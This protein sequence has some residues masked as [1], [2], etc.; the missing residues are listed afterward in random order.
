MD[1]KY[2]IVQRLGKG[3]TG[4]AYLARDKKLSMKWTIKKINVKD[5]K[6]IAESVRREAMAL[7]RL[8]SDSIARLS[9]IYREGNNICL[10]ME[11][12]EG[13]SLKELIVEKPEFVHKNA[14][15]WAEE[16]TA[17]VSL[18][19]T[20]NPPL[21]YRDMKPGNII[22]KENGKLCL[23]DFGAARIRNDAVSDY[24][25]VGTVGYAAPEQFLGYSDE[26]S[27][28]Y[29]LGKT[30]EKLAGGK[31]KGILGRI[32][33]KA[34]NKDPDKRY[35][36]A[37]EMYRALKRMNIFRRSIP[38]ILGLIILSSA[39]FLKISSLTDNDHYEKEI[40]DAKE[41]Y[42][43]L[44]VESG[45]AA[46]ALKSIDEYLDGAPPEDNYELCYESGI[47]ALFELSDYEK[48]ALY[49]KKAEKG[50][51]KEATYLKNISKELAVISDDKSKLKK[52]LTEF[53][54]YNRSK[55]LSEKKIRNLLYIARTEYII[56]P[57]LDDKEKKLMIE[58]AY[59]DC[60]EAGKLMEEVGEKGGFE[61]D[62]HEL[63]YLIASEMGLR[64]EALKEGLEWLET[65][66]ARDKENALRRVDE[67][68]ELCESDGERNEIVDFYEKI[69][70]F[71]PYDCGNIYLKHLEI[72]LREKA[73]K[74][75]LLKLL[76]EASLCEGIE[77]LK[78]YKEMEK[79]IKEMIYDG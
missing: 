59:E 66:G 24:E 43:K 62:C 63:A 29:A 53:R 15:K 79:K 51:I 74:G 57:V 70:K 58:A 67:M 26:R 11:Y 60:G 46:E 38:L 18:L 54:E 78:G 49:F 41:E 64:K 6:D 61:G 65:L 2:E 69:E 77:N 25:S 14:A 4:T 34:C 72:L 28:V 45:K 27:D 3:G 30:I 44:S 48:A 47:A 10:C 76:K 36:S 71:Y 75:E 40:A 37:T 31:A 20:M 7:R 22:L 16:I 19:H 8:R 52:A 13:R 68:A 50:N 39:T 32:I 23:I 21:I 5:R 17:T 42:L 56:C 55:D 9:D 1:K 33:K 12:V 73:D 35:S